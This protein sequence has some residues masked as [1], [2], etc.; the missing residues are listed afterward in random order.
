MVTHKSNNTESYYN[1]GIASYKKR[2]YDKAIIEFSEF[3]EREPDCA[4]AYYNRGNAYWDTV[5]F[6]KAIADYTKT[7]ELKPNYADAY[8]K[9]G[10]VYAEYEASITKPLHDFSVW[11]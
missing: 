10:R 3:I 5:D 6:D 1:R 8:Y 2:E 11:Q 9:R 7:I 4:E